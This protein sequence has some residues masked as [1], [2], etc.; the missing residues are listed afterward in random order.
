[1]NSTSRARELRTIWAR[2]DAALGAWNALADPFAAEL[3]CAP[4]VDYVCIDQQHGLND[5]PQMLASLRAI[6]ARGLVPFTRV[7]ANEAWMIGK[8]LDSGVQGVIV[9][10]INNPE[11]AKRA[12]AACRY[13]G[14]IRSYGPI[15]ASLAMDS[16]DTDV[17]GNEVLCFVMVETRAGL[18]AVEAIAAVP[19]LDG[20]Y[21]GP[22][23]LALGLGLPPDLDKQEPEHVAAVARILK[24]C[25]K[26][27]IVPGIQCGSGNAAK[28]QIDAGFRL[29]TFAKD[30]SLIVS[31]LER[32]LLIVRPDALS[33]Q[34]EKG[35][36]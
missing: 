19:G 11:D 6:E 22:A 28:A 9:P 12:V 32:D 24:A 2:G 21:V 5:Y 31:A 7:P 8:A 26:A 36:V 27:G 4:G 16:R 10:L 30:S 1:M 35:Y 20:I 14:G 18:E 29:V 17:L 34:R 3:M 25:Q 23:D 13:K 15:R 33:K